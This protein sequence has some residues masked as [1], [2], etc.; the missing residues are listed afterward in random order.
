MRGIPWH[1]RPADGHWTSV[2][3]CVAGG[4]ALVASRTFGLEQRVLFVRVFV[5]R[6]LARRDIVNIQWFVAA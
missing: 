4:A 1:V 2:P 3:V 5:L 6:G